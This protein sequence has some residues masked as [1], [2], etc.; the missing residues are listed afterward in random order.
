MKRRLPRSEHE[1][2]AHAQREFLRYRDEV[3]SIVEAHPERK[4]WHL[5]QLAGFTGADRTL[6]R[7]IY[8]VTKICAIV[9]LPAFFLFAINTGVGVVGT[10]SAIVLGLTIGGAGARWLFPHAVRS[11]HDRFLQGRDFEHA[12]ISLSESAALVGLGITVCDWQ[13]PAMLWVPDASNHGV[14]LFTA[15]AFAVPFCLLV[16]EGLA[17]WA[18]EAV[19]VSV[20]GCC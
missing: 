16:S 1:H 14:S 10:V 4:P 19:R 9:L 12:C 17:Y 5:T 8:K 15:I 11:D 18:S 13:R 7:W 6:W 2:Y 20:S 3:F